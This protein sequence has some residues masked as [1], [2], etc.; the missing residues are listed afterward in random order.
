MTTIRIHKRDPLAIV[1]EAQ[2]EGAAGYDLS[3]VEK[4]K[5]PVGECALV[6]T[7]IGVEI[8]QG[9][10]GFVLPRSGLCLKKGLTVL[11]A[12][13]LIDSDYR[14]NV[15]VL[16]Y[17]TS[18]K[19]QEVAAGDRIAQL[20]LMKHEQIRWMAVGALSGTERGDGG[21]GSTDAPA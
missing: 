6:D 8:P 19:I 4:M 10:A 15:K 5:V 12:P 14:G 17:N 2:S 20:V 13:G 9:Y 18:T 3:S 21:F 11:N 1:P 16:L 7:G